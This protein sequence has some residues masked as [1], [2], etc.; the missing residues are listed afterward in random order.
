M[1]AKADSVLLLSQL[2]IT[3]QIVVRVC[4]QSDNTENTKKSILISQSDAVHLR[5]WDHVLP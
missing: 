1:D 5:L 3:E 4:K 2:F